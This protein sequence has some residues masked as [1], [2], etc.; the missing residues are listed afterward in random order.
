[1]LRSLHICPS[2]LLLCGPPLSCLY[3][4]RRITVS[5]TFWIMFKTCVVI[6]F[7]P[8]YSTLP[9][10]SMYSCT[11][12]ALSLQNLISGYECG[13]VFP[14][15]VGPDSPSKDAVNWLP[16]RFGLLVET[17][18]WYGWL[19]M[20]FPGVCPFRA[21]I[22]CPSRGWRHARGRKHCRG[23]PL[24]ARIKGVNRE[25]YEGIANV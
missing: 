16:S 20:V 6:L 12:R 7:V 19:R 24:C 5:D 11:Y 1:M 21:P 17:R 4:F 2:F 25:V 10:D 8:S 22:W 14:A 15:G 9:Q 13:R 23:E 3:T 18:R